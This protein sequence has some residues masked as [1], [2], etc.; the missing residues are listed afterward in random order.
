MSRHTI[1]I[2]DVAIESYLN[3]KNNKSAY[4]RDLIEADMRGNQAEVVGLETQIE[5]LEKQAQSHAEQEQMF[6]DQAEELR[7]LKN[8]V[9]STTATNLEK[10]RA[11]LQDTPKDPANPAIQKWAEKVNLSPTELCKQLKDN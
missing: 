9:E 2:D 5:T 4:I 11:K 7:E 3:S 6:Q 10:A 8:Q 1:R